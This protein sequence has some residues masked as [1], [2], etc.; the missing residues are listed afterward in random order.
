MSLS[1]PIVRHWIDEFVLICKANPTVTGCTVFLSVAT[2]VLIQSN[3]RSSRLT[4]KQQQTIL[5]EDHRRRKTRRK[6]LVDRHFFRKL[7]IFIKI[8]I[9]SWKSPEF[10]YLAVFSAFLVGRT[11]LSIKVSEVNGALVKAIMNLDFKAFLRGWIVLAM[12]AIPSSTLNSMLRFL[13]NKLALR[14][15]SRLVHHFND[16][17]MHPMMYY[18]VINVDDRIKNPDQALTTTIDNWSKSVSKLYSDVTKPLLDIILFSVRL[19]SLVGPEGPLS[20]IFYYFVVGTIIRLISPSFGKLTARAQRFE[21][22]YRHVHNRLITYSEEVAFYGGHHR[23]KLTIDEHYSF[24]EKHTRYLIGKKFWM[25]I[26]DGFLT[27]YGTVMMGYSVLGL[28]VFGPRR[29][30]YLQ[31]VSNDTSMIAHDYIRNSSLLI[32]LA[33]AI[34]RIVASYRDL[35]KLAGYTSLV[36]ELQYVLED[37]KKGKYHRKMINEDRLKELNFAPNTGKIT[38]SD[39]VEFHQVPVV[40]PNGDILV[41]PVDLLIRP[42]MSV[43]IVGPNGCGKS[44]LFRILGGLWPL[45]GGGLERPDPSELFYIPQKP[46]LTIGTL[47]DQVIYPDSVDEF[48]EKGYNDRDLDKLFNLVRLNYIPERLENGWDTIDDWYDVLSGGEKQRVS[49]ARLFYSKPRFAVLDECT[50]AVSIDVEG[51]MYAH[52]KREGIALITVSHRRSLWKY[53][54]FLFKFDESGGWSFGK[55]QLPSGGNSPVEANGV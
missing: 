47:R 20:V 30:Q 51:A 35:Q 22:D 45:F 24:I 21:G 52:C 50:S 39:S 43:M 34:G 2:V 19:S 17:Y 9:P 16:L 31:Q 15:R 32:S 8:A 18:K 29:A 3:T 23:E 44:S 6:N 55:M 36:S 12:F 49:M 54:E 25:G 11:F 38:L 37:L 13:G 4:K 28:P 41:K 5:D 42:G 48:K 40:T 10:A 33:R 53:H 27:K 14:Y 1:K 26:S 46:Y 7:R